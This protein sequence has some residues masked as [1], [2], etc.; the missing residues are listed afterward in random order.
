MGLTR[1]LQEECAAVEGPGLAPA[2][3][4][5][6]LVERELLVAPAGRH[7]RDGEVGLRVVQQFHGDHRPRRRG[8][9]AIGLVIEIVPTH[10]RPGRGRWVRDLRV[11]VR[12]W[13]HRVDLALLVRDLVHVDLVQRHP[14]PDAGIP[15]PI[16]DEDELAALG[17]GYVAEQ[18][19]A[20]AAT[21]SIFRVVRS[22]R[23]GE[24]V[25]RRVLR[26]RHRI[27]RVWDGRHGCR[28]S[29]GGRLVGI[30]RIKVLGVPRRGP[31]RGGSRR[32][33]VRRVVRRGRLMMMRRRR[34]V[35]VVPGH[36]SRGFAD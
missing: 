16:L 34:I 9:S 4:V 19:S 12:A 5:P 35:I 29:R 13:V 26:M 21:L 24:A 17:F 11:E 30:S 28:R 2:H 33:D 7:A 14:H 15:L 18:C 1:S 25:G 8:R 3:A 23:R 27:H 22:S 31:R 6:E 32:R 36:Y 10:P 20:L